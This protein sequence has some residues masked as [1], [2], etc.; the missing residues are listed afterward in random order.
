MAA[1]PLIEARPAVRRRV[2][3]LPLPVP[4]LLSA[5]FIVLLAAAVAAP[6]WFADADP[7]VGRITESLR[8][9]GAGHLLGTDMLGRDVYA[10]M[11]HG[12]RYSLL[13]GLGAMA[14]SVAGGLVLGLLAALSGRWVDEAV[15]RVLD[16]LAA[17]PSVLLA[18][19][20]VAVTEPGTVNVAVAVGVATIPRFGRVVRGEALVIRTADY[21]RHA[22]VYGRRRWRIVSRHIVPNV[23]RIIP[24]LA[25]LDIGL[26]IMSS[27]G[28][29]FLGLGPSSPTPE[30]G[31][32]LAESRDTLQV[33]W[34]TGVFPGLALTLSVI[35][36]TTVGRY[37]QR[38]IQGGRR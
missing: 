32:M 13:I 2:A 33:A 37:T 36:F 9:P 29:S 11:V 21:V 4:V 5:L 10:R 16:T 38:R 34:W 17:F 14:I 18:L 3:A 12:A 19:L 6:G 8:P 26:S 22:V 27:S 23:L 20:V 30:W 7:G 28:L 15:T 35:A 1:E 31:V 25:T 24:V